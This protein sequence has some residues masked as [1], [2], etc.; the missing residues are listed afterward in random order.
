MMLGALVDFITSAEPK[1]FQPMPPN[2]GIL[3]PLPTKVRSK[4]ERYGQYR[5][6]ALSDLHTWAS[7]QSISLHHLTLSATA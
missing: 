2:F 7:D 3:P 4:K 5:D 6:R 1:H